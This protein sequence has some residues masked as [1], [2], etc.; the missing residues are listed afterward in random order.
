MTN[1]LK[2]PTSPELNNKAGILEKM[3]PPHGLF[4]DKDGK[5]Y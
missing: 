1:K 3:R 2:I 5:K 4:G